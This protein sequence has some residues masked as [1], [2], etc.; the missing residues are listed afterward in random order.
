VSIQIDQRHCEIALQRLID[1]EIE[2]AGILLTVMIKNMFQYGDEIHIEKRQEIKRALEQ[3]Q[4]RVREALSRYD[5]LFKELG[6]DPVQPE[7]T[8]KQKQHLSVVVVEAE[9][10]QLGP[11]SGQDDGGHNE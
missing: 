2:K 8:G 11:G 5:D 7:N 10:L 1:T 9:P 6:V 4:K 3:I